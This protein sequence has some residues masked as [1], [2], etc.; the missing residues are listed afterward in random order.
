MNRAFV[1]VLVAASGLV[2]FGAGCQGK[3]SEQVR[4]YAAAGLRLPL[5]ELKG[6]LEARLS[7]ATV[8][9]DYAGTGQLLGKLKT[10][11]APEYRPDI[12]I[13]AE[14]T[15]ALEAKRLGLVDRIET[16][17]YLVPVLAVSKGSQAGIESLA[18]L[19]RPG[20]KVALGESRGPAIGVVSDQIL[21]R[22]G[23]GDVRARVTATGSTVQEVANYIA[24]G[25]VDA[26]IIWDAIATMGDY[27]GKLRV[28]PIPG[29]RPSPILICRVAGCPHPE[30]ADAAIRFLTTSESARGA[31]AK[32][33]VTPVGEAA[34][35]PATRAGP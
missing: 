7:G 1:L 28:I 24:L 26:G 29:A 14:D 4:V 22:A 18:D 17:G 9:F 8:S 33:G 35:Q 12:F 32:Y 11:A 15:F 10:A 6:D 27:R 31:L 19:G 30:L 3:R 20:V 13:A 23:L 16:L 5:D 34:T 21:Q 25:H 2:V